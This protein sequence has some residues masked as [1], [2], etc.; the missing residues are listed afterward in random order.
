MAVGTQGRLYVAEPQERRVRVFSRQ[1]EPLPA[2]GR[3]GSGPGEFANI[4]DLGWVGDTLYVLD[5]GLSRATLFWPLRPQAKVL[6]T[7]RSFFPS[8]Q[9]GQLIDIAGVLRDG[10][11]LL[12]AGPPA[13]ASVA[14]AGQP[15]IHHLLRQL[16]HSTTVLA[17]VSLEHHTLGVTRPGAPW[18]G[19]Y[20][21]QPFADNPLWFLASRGAAIWIVDRR[22]AS[23]L[24]SAAARII[25]VSPAGDTLLDRQYFYRPSKLDQHRIDSAVEALTEKVMRARGPGMHARGTAENA[26]KKAL[27]NP[28]FAAPFDMGFAANDG[29]L[30]LRQPPERGSAATEWHVFDEQGREIARTELRSDVRLMAAGGGKAFGVYYDSLQV[31]FVFGYRIDEHP[32]H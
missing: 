1:G 2:I 19:F 4:S 29:T 27:Y 26:V 9:V 24:D 3:N 6:R 12:D 31:P 11:I 32:R 16:D 23:T 7:L 8:E 17:S 10:S 25:K 30:W 21:Q 20:T 13:G 22:A 28:G 15:H 18:Q 5:P 14:G